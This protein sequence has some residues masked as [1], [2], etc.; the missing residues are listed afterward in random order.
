MKINK[1]INFG[2]LYDK[3]MISANHPNVFVFWF[4]KDNRIDSKSINVE[5]RLKN[6]EW[7]KSLYNDPNFDK[8]IGI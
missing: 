7:L 2:T 6:I 3:M 8:I 5:N 4:T 1:P